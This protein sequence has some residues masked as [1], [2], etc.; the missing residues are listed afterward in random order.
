MEIWIDVQNIIT[1]NEN[2]KELYIQL[3]S[4]SYIYRICYVHKIKYFM[5]I[6]IYICMYIYTK[7]I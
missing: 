7:Y 2:Y 1:Y 4:K 5:Y 3:C 6:Y